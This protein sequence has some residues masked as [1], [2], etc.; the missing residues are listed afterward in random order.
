M[1]KSDIKRHINTLTQLLKFHESV[2]GST[3]VS[4]FASSKGLKTVH[5]IPS[6][7][8]ICMILFKIS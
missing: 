8:S 2:V 5:E 6:R 1:R 4:L 7:E 3:M